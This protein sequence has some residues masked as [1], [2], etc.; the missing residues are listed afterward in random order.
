MDIAEDTFLYS[1][2]DIAKERLK[3]LTEAGPTRIMAMIDEIYT[4]HERE[5]CIGVH[6]DMFEKVHLQEIAAV[7]SFLLFKL[8][9]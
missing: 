1:R 3:Q 2:E 5:M 8:R 6:W 9:C 4:T 7:R